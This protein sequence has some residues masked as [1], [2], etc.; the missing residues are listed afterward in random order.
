M[1]I[2]ENLFWEL[3]EST[4]SK[5]NDLNG[6]IKS[7]TL[8][9][10]NKDNDFI[11]KFECTFR[12]TLMKSYHYNVMAAQK[13]IDNYVSDDTFL[14]FRCAALLQGKIP[15]YTLI[16]STNNYGKFLMIDYWGEGLLFVSDDAYK[17]KNNNVNEND[18]PSIY[19]SL[20]NYDFGTHVILGEYWESKREIKKRFPNLH[21][22]IK[23]RK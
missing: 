19:A 21:N 10:T 9:L 6:Q 12:E 15:Y 7:L 17:Q 16:D 5:S 20:I 14:Y 4:K 1:K 11:K 3:I 2:D 8:E 22:D 18:L 13:L 23:I